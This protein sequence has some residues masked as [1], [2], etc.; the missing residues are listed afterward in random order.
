[1][2]QTEMWEKAGK[3][4]LFNIAKSY[5]GREPVRRLNQ[6]LT[7]GRLHHIKFI[8]EEATQNKIGPCTWII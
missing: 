5:V 8:I 1:M 4:Q 7:I 6:L 2:D 3:K